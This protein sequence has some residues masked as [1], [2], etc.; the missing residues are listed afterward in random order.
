[1]FGKQAVVAVHVFL[2][3][4]VRVLLAHALITQMRGQKSFGPEGGL[5]LSNIKGGHWML[6][7]PGRLSG[8]DSI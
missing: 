5:G 7:G 6:E 1:M 2:S 3:Q 4:K 8:G